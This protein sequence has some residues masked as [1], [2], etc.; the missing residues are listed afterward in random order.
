MRAVFEGV[1]GIDF[2]ELK[3]HEKKAVDEFETAAANAIR[4][5]LGLRPQDEIIMKNT[6]KT[7][8]I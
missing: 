5:R 1:E 2:P 7:K 4:R 6:Y 8:I 3:N